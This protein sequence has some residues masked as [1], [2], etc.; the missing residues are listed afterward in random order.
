[1]RTAL[2]VLR[3]NLTDL[4]VPSHSDTNGTVDCRNDG[5][6]WKSLAGFRAKADLEQALL[7]NREPVKQSREFGVMADTAGI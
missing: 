5:A 6:N 7:G 4:G 3:R 2:H 1:M